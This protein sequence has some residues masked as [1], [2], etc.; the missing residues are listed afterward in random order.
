M[1]SAKVKDNTQKN[2]TNMK[3]QVA[4][5]RAQAQVQVNLNSQVHQPVLAHQLKKLKK[6]M[7]NIKKIHA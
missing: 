3:S 6:P 5:D 7:R 1:R 2:T 4:L